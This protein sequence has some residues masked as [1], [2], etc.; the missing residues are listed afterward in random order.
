VN[1]QSRDVVTFILGTLISLCVLAGLAV[2]YVLLPWLQTHLLEPVKET[3]HQVSV[4]A[5]QSD[6]PTIPDRIEDL[7]AQVTAATRDHVSQGRD[8]RAL[9][10]VLD[11]HLRW[12]NRWVDEVDERLEKLRRQDGT[13]TK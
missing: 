9:T 3:N 13:E 1:G 2:R 5:H 6:E 11:E 7:S 12:S 10:R 8:I 4:N